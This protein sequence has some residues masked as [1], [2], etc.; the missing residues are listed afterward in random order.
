MKRTIFTLFILLLCYSVFATTFTVNGI[1]YTTTGTS[2]VAVTSGGT[3]TGNIMIPSSVTNGGITYNVTSIGDGAFQ[4]CK[5]LTSMVLP[6]SVI[7]IGSWAFYECLSLTYITS[8]A[9]YPPT[10]ALGT[11]SY[12]DKV[13]A[14]YVPSGKKTIYQNATGWS[15]FTNIKEGTFIPISFTS[16]GINYSSISATT[17]AVIAGNTK[18]SGNINIPS[19]VSNLEVTYSVTSIGG[20]AFLDCDGLVF[21]TLPTSLSFIGYEAFEGCTKLL[22]ITFPASLTSISDYAFNT[23]TS[24][25][26]II[27][28]A[29]TPPNISKYVFDTDYSTIAVYVP[30][31]RSATYKNATGWS[32]FTNI[33]EG[34]LV[35]T[36]FSFDGFNYITTSSTSMAIING[37]SK[38]TGSIIVPT[39][40][41]YLGGT[42]TVS[43][44]GGGAFYN[45]ENLTSIDLPTSIN[46]IGVDA[47]YN[48]KSITS[49]NFPVSLISINAL[50][51][52]D[53][54]GL[55]A[56]TL[57]ASVTSIGRCAFINCNNIAYLKSY[58]TIPPTITGNTFAGVSNTIPVYVPA[59]SISAYKIATWWKNFT[60]IIELSTALLIL[61]EE[62]IKI[63]PNPIKDE[64][65]IAGM[66][67]SYIIQL[68]DLNGKELIFKNINENENVSVSTLPKGLYILK[69]K[70]DE[71]TTERKLMKE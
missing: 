19:T 61:S 25:T 22:T 34:T 26:S 47:F 49:I 66:K 58:A 27:S 35:P 10:T 7:S 36:T 20:R 41:S 17:V 32:N 42:Y 15:D 29:L 30:L 45:C 23:C 46:M 44:I 70:A 52:E 2:T 67:G 12:V 63:Y 11:F 3:Y 59:S 6:S 40:V 65:I 69:I 37:G 38:N 54:S 33:K 55:S 56:I 31:G 53:C 60:N 28:S 57:P 50:A 48:C 5:G 51:F 64:F 9:V 8:N 13:I 14:V 68:S 18:Y 4:S 16:D 62:S 24:L 71:G 21:I 39:T 1:K 43:S